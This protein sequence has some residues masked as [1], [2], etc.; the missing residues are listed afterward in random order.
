MLSSPMLAGATSGRAGPDDGTIVMVLAF[1]STA[2]TLPSTAELPPS[3]MTL[4]MVG[5]AWA[6]ARDGS[7]MGTTT[8]AQKTAVAVRKLRRLIIVS[9]LDMRCSGKI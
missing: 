8:D 4:V 2:C 1:G 3:G 5:L 7:V 9:L 6:T